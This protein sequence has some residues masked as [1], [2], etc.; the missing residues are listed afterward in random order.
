VNPYYADGTCFIYHG[1]WQEVLC[2]LVG[3]DLVIADPPYGINVDTAD[4]DRLPSRPAV[5][6][7]TVKWAKNSPAVIGDAEP[8]D[9]TP[10]LR[11]RRLVLF[12]GNNFAH[13]LPPGGDW[14][15]WD[16]RRGGMVTQGWK[17]S[18]AELAW[19]N[20]GGGLVRVFSHL[21]AGYKR[22]SE[23]G[24]HYH[25]TQKPVALM[26]WIIQRYTRPGDLI[27]DPYMG[28]GPVLRAAKDLGRKAVGVE[29]EERYCEIAAKRLGQEVLAL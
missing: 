22:D 6:A 24:Q 16:K 26:A 14:L 29:I 11:F 8:F 2:G 25:P 17:S 19:T 1:D 21:W 7:G 4:A 3:A 27:L 5:S 10:L 23:I 15:V 18:D 9:P 20:L 28:S 12:G 13:R